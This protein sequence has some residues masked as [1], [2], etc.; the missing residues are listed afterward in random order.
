MANLQF[1]VFGLVGHKPE[2]NEYDFMKQP[3][4]MITP[5]LEDQRISPTM[6]M[7][8][9]QQQSSLPLVSFIQKQKDEQSILNKRPPIKVDVTVRV[10][11]KPK[12]KK[13]YD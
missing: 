3:V 10:V 4:N 7:V 1:L 8:A 12:T 2:R 5:S 13:L 9:M 6:D 11:P